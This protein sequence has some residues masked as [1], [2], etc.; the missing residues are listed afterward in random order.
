MDPIVIFLVLLNVVPGTFSG[1]QL[2]QSGPAMV[3]P[4]GSFRLTCTVSGF[5]VSD[6]Y[7]NWVRKHPGRRLVWLG[8]IRNNARQGTT[9]YNPAFSSRISIS[10]DTSRNEAYL[11]LSSLT[12]ADSATYYCVKE[13]QR[14]EA[15]ERP[16]CDYYA[17]DYW[18]P[19]TLVTV[20]SGQK[21]AP[22][23]F[24]LVPCCGFTPGEHQESVTFACLATGYF[25]GSAEITWEP[26]V[27]SGIKT[28]PEVH[29]AA[30]NGQFSSSSQFTV[31]SADFEKN[32]YTCIVKHT[33]ITKQGGERKRIERRD[34]VEKKPIQVR[35]LSPDC[36]ADTEINLEI[37]CILLGSGPGQAEVEW[38]INGVVKQRKVKVTLSGKQGN[39]YSSYITQNITKKSWDKGDQYTCQVT[40][41][42]DTQK[43]GY[44]TSKCKACY[45]SM[46]A[47]TVS[48][49]KPSYRDLV[50]GTATV[51]CLVEASF[52][53]NIQITWNVNGSP[54]TSPQAE[55]V[56]TD[57]SGGKNAKSSHPVSLEQWKGGTTFQ[58]KVATMCSEEEITKDVTIKQDTNIQTIKPIVTISQV[59]REVSSNSTI[60]QILVCDVS[61]FF[62]MEIS[63][64]W[65]KN[66]VLLDSSLY[67]NGP[68][69]PSGNAYTTYSILKI[70]RNEV[71]DG[72]DSYAN[73]YI[74]VVHHSSSPKPITADEIVSS[75]FLEPASPQVMAFHISEKEAKHKLIC[76]ATGFHPKNIDIQWS[77][78]GMDLNCSSDSS[79]LV[80]LSDGKY[81]KSCNLAL[82]E[83]EWRE[84][85]TYTCTV[86]HSST[87]TS[88]KKILYSSGTV[89]TPTN[90]TVISMQP[91]PLED[92][93]INN[94]AALTCLAPL[95]D[96]MMNWT[97]SWLMDGQPAH[98]QA[99]IT[100][101]WNET[102]DTAWIHSQLVVNL[103]EWKATT[104]F[105]CGISTGLGEVKQL[106][107]RRNGTM[108]PPKVYL[109]QQS[110]KEDQNVTL[111]CVATDFYPGE[112]FVK[113]QEENTEVSLKGHDAHDLKCDHE[114]ERCSLLSILEVPR[115]QWMMGVSYTCLVAHV[116]SANIIIR[117]ANSHSD[118]WG[119]AFTSAEICGICNE[120][121][122]EYSELTEIDGAWNRVSTY[123]ILFLLALF[124]GGLVT[125]FKVKRK[126]QKTAP[127]VFPLV[128]C[129]GSTPGE[130]QESVTFA[131]LATGYFPG[132]AEITWEPLVA[133]G[134]KT[135]PE[136]HP[137]ANNGQFSSSSQ[138]TVPS[139]DFEKNSY[140]CIVKH[141]AI[142]KQ[143]GERK[144]IERRDC[145]EIKPIQVRLLTPDC[146]AENTETSLE[147]VCILLSSGPGQA[148]VEWL[149]NG[150][151]EQTKVKVTL[152]GKE[153]NG[154]SSSV[155]QNITKKSWD[156]GDQYTCRVTHPPDTQDIKMYNTSKCKACYKS[157]QT[158][159][160]SITKPSYRDLVE[161]TATVTCLVEASFLENI[162]ITWNVNG[163]PSTNP[164]AEIVKTDN[165]GRK[166]AKSSHPVSLEQWKGGTTFQCKVATMCSEEEITKD[167]TIKQD[168][169]IPTIKPIVTITQ[170]YREVS[171]N[172]TIAQI[173]NGVLLDSSLYDNGPV[174]PSGNAYT[175]YSIL[176]IGRNEVGDGKD[177]YASVIY[178]SSSLE[179]MIKAE[180]SSVGECSG[181]PAK[182]EAIP[183]SFS[184]I[185]LTKSVKLTCRISNIPSGQKNLEELNVT[186][187]RERDNKQLE[188]KIGEAKEQEN[189]D[190]VFVDATAAVNPEEW[191][192][193][194]TFTCKVTFPTFLPTTTIKTL[195]R[196]N[197]GTPRA[198]AVYV[199]PPP[200][201]QLALRETATVTCL[202]KGFYPND[203]FV[204]WLR[205]DEPVGASDYFTSKPVQESR[206]PERYFTYSTLTIE[207]QDW[208]YGATYTCV[209]GHEALPLQTTQKTIDKNMGKPTLVNV[210]L[211]LSETANTCYYSKDCNVMGADICVICNGT[212]DVYWELTEM[213]GACYRV[214]T[215]LVLFLLSLSYAGLVTLF[216]QT[217][218]LPH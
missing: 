55:I 98:A 94:S 158:P 122:E 12:A 10:R 166:N 163:S 216:K 57:N 65:K 93:F 178:H 175:T 56:K 118:S 218:S 160:V 135:F 184:D 71:G 105:T 24:P 125:F 161:G 202:M 154:Y 32:S 180:T 198:P 46:Q 117:R 62:P 6:H 99:V 115:S 2:A 9:Q 114:R 83:E 124:Y 3:K 187:T 214:S 200:S 30:N 58:C 88:I 90:T 172:S 78:P 195:R 127:S 156:K 84:P 157:M 86:N 111:L 215:Y 143:G 51:T 174:L 181:T 159:T 81:Q 186:W 204:K 13:P 54:S 85:K 82:S 213:E 108:K 25:P 22:S 11:Q 45:K 74:C 164:P 109:Q 73:S 148:D 106:Y 169:N 147:I 95:A 33:A 100:E 123:L 134:I 20:S 176:K 59:Y 211:V 67:D 183:P 210:S 60:A 153:G 66:G 132:S 201:E 102:T 7:W 189:S 41:L 110:S 165:G 209:V 61:G 120:T 133:S 167:V 44:N 149:I 116:S 92:L 208:S 112:V 31:P 53:E 205:N 155:A 217:S 140:T 34:C 188:T 177:S 47:P 14:D 43:I 76:L 152:G 26:L 42:P 141:T 199:L 16:D 17:F 137:A 101:V 151:V 142:T 68:V 203:F 49:T 1:P 27:A 97:V 212:E 40:L 96:T 103:T 87:N 48:I 80:A 197:G 72:K 79:A 182:V 190:L 107:Q 37:V 64:S 113:W 38:L 150:V 50:E 75:D 121:E 196:L 193:N 28:F 69:L 146:D 144:R 29:P 104:K 4:G 119:S 131:C 129:C 145:V 191:E 179:P 21:T 171:S 77:V 207:E 136:V 168:T 18:G 5:R 138:F 130:H 139:A 126:R 35:L 192:R 185:Y 36:D 162:Q 128:P 15:M 89:S 173:L 23:V 19:G 170:V 194:Y 39:S 63:I 8:F 70:G 52:L 206:T 91:P